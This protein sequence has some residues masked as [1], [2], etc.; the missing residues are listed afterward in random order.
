[1]AAA[2]NATPGA[3]AKLVAQTYRGNAGTGI[4]Q[5]RT[6]GNLSDFLD[7][8]DER[9]RPARAVRVLRDADRQEPAR[10]QRRPGRHGRRVGVFLYCQQHARE[11]AT[12]LTC[13]ETAE[14]LLRN[15][16][17]D[18]TT[19][20]LVDEL[21]IFILPS[22]NPDGAHYS[23]HNFNSQR[24]TMTNWC[25]NGGLETDDPNAANFWTPRP[26]LLPGGVAQPFNDSAA[27]NAWGTDMNRNNTFGTLIDGYIGAS[28]SCIS[29]VFAGPSEASEPEI[30]NE[31]WV[32]DTFKNIKF[33]NNIH[34]FGGYFMWAPGTYL[35]DRGEG[36]AVH[37]NIGVE[38]YFFEAGDRILNRIKDVRNTAILPERT[39]PIADVLYSAAGNSADEHWYNRGVIAYS[40][41]T[42]ADRFGA[43]EQTTLSVASAAGATARPRRATGTCS[44]RSRRSRSTRVCRPRRRGRCCPSRPRTRR[45][46]RR[47]SRSPSRS[48]SR[49]R[50][51]R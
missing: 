14:Q 34:S 9:A 35:P 6:K 28:T 45:A 40:F 37:A 43:L 1:M 31:L 21:D 3:F 22:S 49:T 25:V 23:M 17:I 32:A 42:G 5:P 19:R 20:K 8:G 41:E 7:D 27:R 4:V 10:Q 2:I 33:S 46:R 18:K 50:P 44:R 38:K 29:E 24:K 15:Y 36:D 48:S 12:P 11:W 51:A 39:G 26:N 30:K 47:T 16:G 13:L